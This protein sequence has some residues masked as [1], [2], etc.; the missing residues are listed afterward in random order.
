VL[1]AVRRNI[2]A[3][4][5]LCFHLL[6]FFEP[7]RMRVFAPTGAQHLANYQALWFR[8]T[9]QVVD[10]VTRLVAALDSA[11]G[12]ELTLHGWRGAHESDALSAQLRELLPRLRALEPE[13]VR[14]LLA[15]NRFDRFDV[16]G[17]ALVLEHPWICNAFLDRLVLELGRGD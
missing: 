12:D 13:G 3:L 17:G 5:G 14:M 15:R 6:D 16:A 2:D 8:T 1:A 7:Q 4:L 11:P 10:E 9:E